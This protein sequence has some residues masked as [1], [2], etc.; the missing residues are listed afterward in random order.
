MRTIKCQNCLMTYVRGKWK[1]DIMISLTE[2]TLR[3]G[4]LERHIPEANPRVLSRQLRA[5]ESD[6]LV[7]RKVYAE[8]PLKVEYSLTDK[9]WAIMKL[10]KQMSQFTAEH[11][12]TLKK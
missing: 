8:V 12:K 9:G 6:G 11:C 10:L 4:E 1:L 7:Q 2:G 5:L 3:M